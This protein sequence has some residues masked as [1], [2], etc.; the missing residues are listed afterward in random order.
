MKRYRMGELPAAGRHLFAGVVAGEYIWEEAAV[1]F[2]KP[3]E[4]VPWASH[5]DEEVYVI[6]QGKA[7]VHLEAGVE[8]LATGDVMVIEPG[9]RHQF[10]SDEK[11][12]CVQ[13][14]VHCGP[15]L[16][17]NQ[18]APQETSKGGG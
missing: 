8:H 18:V 16:H 11:E 14:Y 1:E 13:M 5:E 3:G 2:R 10:V 15:K 7:R 12:P 9:E 17:A 4:V 6:L